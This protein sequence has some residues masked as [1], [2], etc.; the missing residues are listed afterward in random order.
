M[1][2]KVPW[3]KI[4]E[5]AFDLSGQLWNEDEKDIRRIV[6]TAP[7]GEEIITVSFSHVIDCTGDTPTIKTKISFSEKFSGTKTGSVDDPAQMT[8]GEEK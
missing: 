8:L 6:D 1:A 5:L 3:R 7:E 2:K 4:K